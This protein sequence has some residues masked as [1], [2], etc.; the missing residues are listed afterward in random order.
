MH[1]T[2]ETSDYQAIPGEASAIRFDFGANWTRFLAVVSEKHIEAA[3]EKLSSWLGD[4]RGKTFL[5]VGCGSGIHSL[6][7]LRLGASRVFSIDY[8]SH[9]V[10]CTQ[11]MKRRFAPEANWTIERGSVLDEC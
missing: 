11:E 1:L 10:G 6:A 8:D 5:D 4:L 2:S 3:A 9:S 7:A